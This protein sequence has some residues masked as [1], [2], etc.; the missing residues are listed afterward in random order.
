MKSVLDPSFR[1]IDSAHTDIRRTFQRIR[2][3]QE[4]ARRKQEAL[5]RRQADERAPANDDEVP[6]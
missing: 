3:E 5:D 4:Q 1:Y 2:F 6:A